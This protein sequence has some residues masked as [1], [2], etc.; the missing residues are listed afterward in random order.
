MLIKKEV[1]L[2]TNKS[3]KNYLSM[4]ETKLE[5]LNKYLEEHGEISL[6]VSLYKTNEDKKSGNKSSVYTY[7][8][9]SLKK[10]GVRN[11][12]KKDPSKNTY[13][14]KYSNEKIV[15]EKKPLNIKVSD[16]LFRYQTHYLPKPG[17]LGFLDKSIRGSIKDK[18]SFNNSKKS[19]NIFWNRKKI[20]DVEVKKQLTYFNPRL[21]N[22]KYNKEVEEKISIAKNELIEKFDI[23]LIKLNHLLNYTLICPFQRK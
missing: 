20:R 9:K 17:S 3:D 5:E 19:S 2:E 4:T 18:M 21:G 12:N 7:T 23:P 1:V 10:M 13:R 11:Y 16:F 6:M 22:H 15:E 8:I 14:V